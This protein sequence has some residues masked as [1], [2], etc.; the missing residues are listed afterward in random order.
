MNARLLRVFTR[1]LRFLAEMVT[2]RK[3]D[4]VGNAMAPNVMHGWMVYGSRLAYRSRGPARG[5]IVLVRN[6]TRRGPSFV[7]RIVG[8]PGEV[9]SVQ[10][11]HTWIDGQPFAERYVLGG[12]DGPGM[13]V[14]EEEVANLVV[15][16]GS[17]PSG[18]WQLADAE[19]FLMGDNRADS[20]DSRTYGPF[21][22]KAILGKVWWLY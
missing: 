22:R 7:R 4:V 13:Q 5:D 9:V 20:P 15:P 8:L 19:Y 3:L 12:E 11:G 16:P 10:D 18:E 6:P 21:P 2:S 17:G 1:P 14:S